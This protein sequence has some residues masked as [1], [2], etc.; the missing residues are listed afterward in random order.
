[1]M[2]VYVPPCEALAVRGSLVGLDVQDVVCDLVLTTHD[3]RDRKYD[4]SF[5]VSGVTGN[6][7]INQVPVRTLSQVTGNVRF[8]A[9]NEFVNVPI[10]TPRPDYTPAVAEGG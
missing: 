5:A 6:V 8:V 4:G 1:M 3:S 2:T 10:P 7:T 9:T